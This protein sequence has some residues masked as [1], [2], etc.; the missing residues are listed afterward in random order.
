MVHFVFSV[1]TFVLNIMI[2]LICVII[3]LFPY[4]IVLFVVSVKII[5]PFAM[6]AQPNVFDPISVRG[7]HQSNH[8]CF[9]QNSELKIDLVS[10]FI[11]ETNNQLSRTEPINQTVARF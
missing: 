6:F 2:L 5:A 10:Q 1:Q 4:D 8:I 3:N 11:W 7:N 9:V